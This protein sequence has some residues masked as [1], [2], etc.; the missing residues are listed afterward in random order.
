MDSIE[1]LYPRIL[2]PLGLFV[3]LATYALLTWTMLVQGY[4]QASSDDYYLFMGIWVAGALLALFVLQ[5]LEFVSVAWRVWIRALWCNFGVVALALFVPHSLRMFMLVVPIFALFYAALHVS[6]MQVVAIAVVTWLFYLLA[7]LNMPSAD[8]QMD[9]LIRVGFALCLGGGVLLAWE[10]LLLRDMLSG[11]NQ[12]L[13]T[14]IE[15]VQEMAL[16]DELTG[17]HNRRHILQAL[18]R[19][20]ALADRAQMNFTLCFCDLDHFKRVND[21]FG[22]AIGDAALKQFAGIA[23]GLVRNIDFVG[24]LGGEEFVL[25]LLGADAKEGCRV[26]E[27]LGA[28]TRGMEIDG[29]P[30]DFQLTVSVGVAE[31][32][33]GESVDDLIGRADEAMYAAKAAGRDKV[34]SAA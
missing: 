25:V 29:A 22:H 4:V 30:Q 5:H 19:Q 14:M 34:M 12:E 28:R 33:A 26:A 3:G 32:Q 6:R 2:R 11:N 13:Q 24:R 17:V 16:K 1:T 10:A 20:K 8:P 15:Q 31:Y 27:R 21:R 18:E 7:S 23:D 9:L